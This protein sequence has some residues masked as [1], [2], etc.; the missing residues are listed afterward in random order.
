MAGKNY[1]KQTLISLVAVIF[2]LLVIGLI[3]ELNVGRFHFKRVNILSDVIKRPVKPVDTVSAFLPLKPVYSD[4]CKT[5]VTCIEDYS[6]DSSGLAI[7]LSALDSSR[8]KNIRIAW[9]GDSYVEGDILLGYLRDTLQAIF[10]GEGVGF[11]PITSE[12]A[13]FRQTISHSFSGWKTY[14]MVGEHNSEHPLGPAGYTCTGLPENYVQY[15]A[16]KSR[17]QKTLADAQLFYGNSDSALVTINGATT[18]LEN[19]AGIGKKSAGKNLSSMLLTANG[20]IDLYGMTFESAAGISVDNFSMRGNSGVGLSYVSEKMYRDFDAQHHYDLIVLSYGLNVANEE[21]KNYDWYTRSMNK[22]IDRIKKGFPHSSI[23]LIGCSDRAENIDGEMQTMPS[24]KR[25]I[26]VQRKMAA[27]NQICFWN[28]FEAMGGDS[29]MIQWAGMPK[30]PLANK[31][32]THLT[33][34]GGKRVAEIL[35]NTLLYEQE[36]YKRRMQS[37]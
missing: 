22:V 12:V 15:R 2:L 14:S 36:K 32:Y 4:T 31:D 34:Y 11:M 18:E 9:F 5:G 20:T 8:A 27:E 7:F 28:L 21:S 1:L 6:D 10:G 23:L 3:P 25:L 24:V 17:G 13:G 37:K 29:T 33:F 30:R 35:L 16:V 26:Q 19:I